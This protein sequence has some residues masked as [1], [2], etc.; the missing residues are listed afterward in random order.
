M[1]VVVLTYL[2]IGHMNKCKLF[3]TQNKHIILLPEISSDVL[4][5]HQAQV[6]IIYVNQPIGLL[7]LRSTFNLTFHYITVI[8]FLIIYLFFYS[9]LY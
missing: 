2:K 3:L 7:C 8:T 1:S 5:V 6:K 9:G 4:G